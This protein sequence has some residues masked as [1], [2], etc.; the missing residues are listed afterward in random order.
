MEDRGTSPDVDALTGV[1]AIA[2]VTRA[3]RVLCWGRHDFGQLGDG[4]KIDRSTPT[5]ISVCP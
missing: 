2:A 4:T 1:A 3:G 5:E